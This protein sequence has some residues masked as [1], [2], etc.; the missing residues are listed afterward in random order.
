MTYAF[1]RHGQTDWNRDLLFQGSSDIPLNDLGRQQ[2]VEA[3]AVLAGGEWTAIVSS[4]LQRARETAQIIAD[5]LEIELGPAYPELSE[6]DYG[7]LEGTSTEEALL[8]W[9][10][11]QYPGAESIES[12]VGRGRAGLARIAADYPGENVVI[13]CHGTI[14]RYTLASLAGRTLD[15][16]LNGSISTFRVAGDGWDVLTVN[17]QPLEPLAER[18]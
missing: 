3:A 9:P 16:I 8:R 2:A 11:R 10:D 6:R 7:S 12:V 17:G 13:V 18:D 14:I 15:G 5:E 1:I 4:G